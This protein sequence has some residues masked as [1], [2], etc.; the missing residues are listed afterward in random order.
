[1]FVCVRERDLIRKRGKDEEGRMGNVHLF[2]F[3]IQKIHNTYIHN[4]TP[5]LYSI[6]IGLI[7][8]RFRT[9]RINHGGI[10][11]GT[12]Y[13]I[14][15]GLN[16]SV[17]SSTPSVSPSTFPSISSP[18][19]PPSTSFDPSLL[20]SL[21]LAE[22]E[23]ETELSSSSLYAHRLALQQV[24]NK[25]TTETFSNMM[26][27]GGPGGVSRT[28]F[29]NLQGYHLAVSTSTVP[30]AGEGVYVEGEVKAGSVVGYVPGEVWLSEHLKTP[31]EMEGV[32]EDQHFETMM[33]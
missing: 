29:R 2:N 26:S 27:S 8:D 15:D 12:N 5:I 28:R 11:H 33:R 22:K 1:M 30:N 14:N 9:I 18:S 10:N 4:L 31:M 17:N 23:V 19:P 24:L 13:T 20:T 3:Y 16:D 25:Q 32:K 6:F 21:H 7:L